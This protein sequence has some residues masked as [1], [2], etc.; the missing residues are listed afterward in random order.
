MPWNYKDSNGDWHSGDAG[1]IGD[2]DVERVDGGPADWVEV[3]FRSS[4]TRG[5]MQVTDFIDPGVVMPRI[6]VTNPLDLGL[7]N[8]AT[9]GGISALARSVLGFTP[10]IQSLSL[11]GFLDR[12]IG[13]L[14]P[15]PPLPF[16][17]SLTL[18]SPIEW[19]RNSLRL[20]YP[21]LATVE[22]LRIC[23]RELTEEEMGC[24]AGKEGALPMLK[25]F[26]WSH[27]AGLEEYRWT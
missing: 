20:N 23:G 3:G 11:T 2:E 13:G 14:R 18:G 9:V 26:Q 7:P 19:W 6:D 21:T 25:S 22:R 8:T 24:I 16:L 15:P 17:R 12:I 4:L 1:L 27:L 10:F 5:Q